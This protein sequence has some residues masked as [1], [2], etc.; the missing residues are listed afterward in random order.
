MEPLGFPAEDPVDHY[1]SAMMRLLVSGGCL[2]LDDG[3]ARPCQVLLMDR[4]LGLSWRR[5]AVG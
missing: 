2:R 1:S 4:G 3:R 5:P